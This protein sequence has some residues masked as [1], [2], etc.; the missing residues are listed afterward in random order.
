[1]TTSI[2]NASAETLTPEE[3][4]AQ[5][6]QEA[7]RAEARAEIRRTWASSSIFVLISV[8]VVL[9]TLA[10]GTVHSWS[11]AIFQG[12][13]ALL[14]VLWMVDAWQSRTL[15]FS[16]NPLQL[17]LVGLLMIGIIQLLPLGSGAGVDGGALSVAPTRS[18]SLDPYTTRLV[19]VQIAALFVYFAA[20][21]AFTDS[22]RRLRL[23]VY[24]V[25][26]FG[27]LLAL[28]GLIQH[29]TS[30]TT[31][32]W[33]RDLPTSTP[34]GPFINR[35]HFAGY[36][37]LALALP[38]GLLF[39]GAVERDR[40]LLYGFAVAMMSIAL[41]MTNSRG[42][43]I[44]LFAL[45]CFLAAVS[46]FGRNKEVSDDEEARGS[47]ALRAVVR[48]GVAL[49]L[50]IALFVGVVLLGGESVL[51]RFVGTVNTEDPTTGRAHFWSMTL[52]IIRDHPLVGAGLGAFGLAY[53]RYDTRNGLFRLEQAHNDYLQVM[54]DA[55]VF[56]AIFGLLFI[57]MLFRMGFQRTQTKDKFRRGVA[58]GALAG[59][60]A[61][62]THSFFDFTLHTTSN[63]LLFLV[64]ATL[65]TVNGRVEQGSAAGQSRGRRRRRHHRSRSHSSTRAS[66]SSRSGTLA[67][68]QES[69]AGHPLRGAG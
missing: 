15:R 61:V 18:L 63:A 16:R 17:P 22:P 38:L 2:Y 13:A 4:P 8:A 23:L 25:T 52:N 65:A 60:F 21:L 56:G 28:L 53:T 5:E 6:A 29:F 7:P 48:V 43:I 35:H 30:P 54:A 55:G 40:R 27:F 59:C 68:G 19:L 41:I 9:T 1:M 69:G 26:I 47:R 50:V 46:G 36:M 39:S 14:V 44:S 34:F 31:I 57:V 3:A 11:L 45:I 62:L 32:Y 67:D 24:T 20:A 64:L 42:G 66:A 51:S 37:E 33:F 10:Y 58:L 12:S 49:S